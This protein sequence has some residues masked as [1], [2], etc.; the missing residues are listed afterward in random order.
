MCLVDEVL[1]VHDG[2]RSMVVE[3][4]HDLFCHAVGLAG[5]GGLE[6]GVGSW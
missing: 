4:G 2:H 1:G 5:L 3:D 6:C